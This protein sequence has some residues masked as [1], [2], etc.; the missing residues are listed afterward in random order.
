MSG[1]PFTHNVIC[2]NRE[3]GNWQ[4]MSVHCFLVEER[5]SQQ[6]S[7]C[8]ADTSTLQYFNN[9]IELF[10]LDLISQGNQTCIPLNGSVRSHPP[11]RSGLGLRMLN[12][13]LS[14]D[15]VLYQ[16]AGP[17][18][19]MKSRVVQGVGLHPSLRSCVAP[20]RWTPFS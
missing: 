11:L 2:S 4:I 8:L 15:R 18:F 20:G 6:P 17:H 16:G 5:N 12:S 14:S 13:T 19:P 3:K 7:Q 9:L 10:V 1:V